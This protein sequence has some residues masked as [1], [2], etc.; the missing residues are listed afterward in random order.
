[1]NGLLL[2]SRVLRTSTAFLFEPIVVEDVFVAFVIIV[3]EVVVSSSVVS[4]NFV[5]QYL[6]QTP[7]KTKFGLKEF[8]QYKWKN[9]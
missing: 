8:P 1:M 3:L 7:D 6:S 2:D 5:N 9:A 4:E